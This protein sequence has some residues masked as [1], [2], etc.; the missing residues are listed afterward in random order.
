MCVKLLLPES[1]WIK[2]YMCHQKEASLT[3]CARQE[4]QPWLSLC[5]TNDQLLS[6]IVL[7]FLRLLHI[8]CYWCLLG[9]CRLWS[10]PLKSLFYSKASKLSSNYLNSWTSA[11]HSYSGCGSI[12]LILHLWHSVWPLFLC[13]WGICC[14]VYFIAQLIFVCS[15]KMIFNM[16]KLCSSF[17]M[18]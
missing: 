9:G 11:P 14:L 3:A 2:V 8:W 10:S 12:I 4:L 5:F 6:F 15:Y 7:L 18:I 17:N 1:R 16:T 13:L